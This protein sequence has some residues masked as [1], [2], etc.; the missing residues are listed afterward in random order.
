MADDPEGSEDFAEEVFKQTLVINPSLITIKS[1][2]NLAQIG[3]PYPILWFWV[4]T[5]KIVSNHAQILLF[6]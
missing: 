6:G 5:P 1:R 2:P 3:P 4:F